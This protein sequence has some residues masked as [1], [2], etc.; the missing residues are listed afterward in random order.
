MKIHLDCIPCQQRSVLRMLRL[1]TEDRRI[2]ETVLR[3]VVSLL[4]RSDWGCDPMT[5]TKRSY[6]MITAAT[7][8]LDPYQELKLKSN[9]EVLRM[10]PGLQQLVQNSFNPLLTACKLAVAG[11]IMDFGA[12][13]NFNIQE[14]I[15]YV[16]KTDF[17]ANE[18]VRFATE[19]QEASSLLLFADNAGEI[20]LD[21]LLLET[22]LQRRRLEKL[23]VV[24]KDQ[25]IIND[26]TLQDVDYV[27]LADLPHIE[28]RLANRPSD[29]LSG[30]MPAEIDSWIEEHDMVLSKGQANYESLSEHKGIYFLLIAKCPIV[31]E[32]TGTYEKALI[33]HYTSPDN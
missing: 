5:L 25:A 21:K 13:D 3:D 24:V 2:H 4:A 9:D 17:A 18:Y 20:V 6:D 7:G 1:A 30:W 32:D 31:A 12:M 14:T 28:F 16:L 15:D 19:L 23:T 10:Y 22:I 11:N 8:N 27:G 29:G 33:F 26:A